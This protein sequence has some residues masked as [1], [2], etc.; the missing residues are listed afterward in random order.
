MFPSLL[1]Q[2][3]LCPVGINGD[4]GGMLEYHV[5]TAYLSNSRPL[6][7]MSWLKWLEK[8]LLDVPFVS[9]RKRGLLD[10]N[11]DGNGHQYASVLFWIHILIYWIIGH[12]TTVMEELLRSCNILIRATLV[13]LLNFSQFCIRSRTL[14][15]CRTSYVVRFC[16]CILIQI[17]FAIGGQQSSVTCHKAPHSVWDNRN[18]WKYQRCDRTSQNKST[19]LPITMTYVCRCSRLRGLVTASADRESPWL[20]CLS[21]LLVDNLQLGLEKY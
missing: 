6:M 16:F 11:N 21:W 2:H 15:L 7:L 14:F 8:G 12:G 18:C 20:E 17:A 19:W 1:G 5:S 13:I 9:S 4:V 10:G 3:F